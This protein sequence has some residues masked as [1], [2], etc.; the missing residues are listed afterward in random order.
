MEK[1]RV[2][3]IVDL[4]LETVCSARKTL[5]VAGD[6]YPAEL[7]KAKFMKLDSEHIRFVLDCMRE[8]TTRIRNIR[9][10]LRAA[11]FNA[12]STIYYTSLVSHDMASGAL[13]PP[14]RKYIC[15]E[16]ESL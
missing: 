9:Q 7:V 15:N 13:P 12:P 14:K 2:D 11:L 4:I 5:R 1:D 8:N 16:V 3:E 6:D 10:Y